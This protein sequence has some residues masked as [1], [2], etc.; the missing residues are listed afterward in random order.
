VL[1]FCFPILEA[2]PA[3][4]RKFS[5]GARGLELGSDLVRGEVLV[6][7]IGVGIIGI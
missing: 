4:C 1:T 3:R 2:P 7:L 5:T 6:F